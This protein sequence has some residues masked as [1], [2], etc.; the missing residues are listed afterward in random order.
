ML[1]LSKPIKGLN[2]HIKYNIECYQNICTM[3]WNLFN[4]GGRRDR[5]R[6]RMVV[7]FTTN[8]AIGAYHH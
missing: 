8:C 6:N 3:R 1:P 4:S 2:F 5:N 7:G